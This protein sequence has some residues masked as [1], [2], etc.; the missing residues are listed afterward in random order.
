MNYG[1]QLGFDRF[2]MLV[3][4]AFYLPF[5]QDGNF[6]YSA[7][8]YIRNGTI[9]SQVMYP[10]DKIIVNGEVIQDMFVEAETCVEILDGLFITS[11]TSPSQKH[12]KRI[13]DGI[14]YRKPIL[15]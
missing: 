2:N 9:K 14:Y 13:R 3:D 15:L 11:K 6:W 10:F 4:M 7:D 1:M 12:I 5:D 8:N